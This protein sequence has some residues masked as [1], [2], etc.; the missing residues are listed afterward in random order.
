MSPML[1]WDRWLSSEGSARFSRF[2]RGI[3]GGRTQP[4]EEVDA[5]FLMAFS[6]LTLVVTSV[7]C[8]STY[9]GWDPLVASGCVE[10]KAVD[11]DRQD[12]PAASGQSQQQDAPADS[13][14]SGHSWH[15]GT[16]LLSAFLH[17]GVDWLA[18]I[19]NIVVASV[20]LN[21]GYS[22]DA[23]AKTDA[24]GALICSGLVLTAALALLLAFVYEQQR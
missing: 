1:M 5:G 20:I 23:Q 17:L 3:F 18:S 24:V 10:A 6:V 15:G 12:A 11:A 8:L 22:G 19:V 21:E 14:A 9:Y 16:N 13:A 4:E 7:V 2:E